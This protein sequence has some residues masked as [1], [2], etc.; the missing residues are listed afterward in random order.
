MSTIIGNTTGKS[1]EKIKDLKQAAFA[2]DLT[3]AGKLLS[4][5]IWWDIIVD[6]GRFIGYN[7]KASKSWLIVKEQYIDL[8]KLTFK[9]AGINI[10]SRG[11]RHLGAVIGSED[12]KVEY[13]SEKVDRWM[14]EI[15]TLAEITLVEPHAAY[16]AFVHGFQHKFTFVMRT[17]PEINGIFKRLGDVIIKKLINN[18]FNRECTEIE[19]KIFA[20]PVQLRGFG[21]Y[22]PSEMC[23]IQYKNSLA[24]TKSLVTKVVEQN[25]I[26]DLDEVKIKSIKINIKAEKVK[27]NDQLEKVRELLNAEQN[28]LLEAESESGASSWLNAVWVSPR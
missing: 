15:E 8:A 22:V 16:A 25:V 5:R 23:E 3:R 7:A 11:K 21:I 6:I 27:R 12:F 18:I 10:T 24:V 28:K 20:L 17:I 19:S 2:D 14:S 9:D 1:V 26:L 13:V 4:L